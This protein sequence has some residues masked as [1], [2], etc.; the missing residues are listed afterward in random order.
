MQRHSWALAGTRS[1]CLMS[2]TLLGSTT[3]LSLWKGRGQSPAEILGAAPSSFHPS[4]PPIRFTRSKRHARG[5]EPQP[6]VYCPSEKSCLGINC[7]IN[8]MWDWDGVCAVTGQHLHSPEL[9]NAPAPLTA[10]RVSRTKGDEQGKRGSAPQIAQLP[11][12]PASKA[13]GLAVK[14]L[15]ALELWRSA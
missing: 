15:F 11:A 8:R 2:L 5:S 4:M 3:S 6:A 9:G 13:A 10:Q 14:W 12:N 7:Y 1:P